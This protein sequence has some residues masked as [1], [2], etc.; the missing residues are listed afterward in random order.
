MAHA[1]GP[2]P[3]ICA[4]QEGRARKCLKGD[5]VLWLGLGAS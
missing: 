5:S 2:D 3:T 4:L 1:C